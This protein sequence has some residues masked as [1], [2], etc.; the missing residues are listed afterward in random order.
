M[1]N[2]RAKRREMSRRLGRRVSVGEIAKKVGYSQQHISDVETGRAPG[3]ED[4]A[5]LLASVFDCDVSE[6]LDEKQ[7]DAEP[8]QPEPKQPTPKPTG[9]PRRERSDTKG[10]TRVT[11]AVA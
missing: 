2:V 6:L 9:P 10:P 7:P 8:K 11:G 4:L 3:S 1:Q 5:D